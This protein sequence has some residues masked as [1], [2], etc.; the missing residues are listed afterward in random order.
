MLRISKL[1]DYA[2]VIM[3]YC[4]KESDT[5]HTAKEIAQATQIK[6]PTVSK[7]LK[8]LAKN[9]L[10]N[11]QRGAQGGYTLGR[12][13]A[14]INMADLI[15]AVDGQIALTNCHSEENPC[16]LLKRCS[17]KHSWQVINTAIYQALKSVSLSDML[18]AHFTPEVKL[19]AFK[20]IL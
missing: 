20:K 18:D 16:E 12:Q 13:A 9:N 3:V 8:L 5:P 7:L 6:Q 11:S 15:A 1:A 2:T 19:T 17:T 14:A 10:L 4:A